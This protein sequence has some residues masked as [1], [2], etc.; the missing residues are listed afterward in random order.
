MKALVKGDSQTLAHGA[1]TLGSLL[2]KSIAHQGT[3]RLAFSL[4]DSQV[5]FSHIITLFLEI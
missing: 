5:H 1:A 4:L 2:E 3:P